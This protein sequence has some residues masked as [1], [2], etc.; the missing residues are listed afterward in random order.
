VKRLAEDAA[1]RSDLTAAV[2]NYQLYAQ[3]ERAG[4]ETY[5]LLADLFERQGDAL[6]ALRATEQALLYTAKDRDLLERRDKYYYSVMPEHLR[7]APDHFKQAVDVGYCLTKAKQ[8]L[9]GRDLDLDL[10]DWAQ[11]LVELALVLKPDGVLARVLLA[12]A[13]LR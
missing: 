4:V 9:D 3:Y 1:A 7:A 11:H 13:R 10:L 6:S 2:A 8:L 5:R 12:R